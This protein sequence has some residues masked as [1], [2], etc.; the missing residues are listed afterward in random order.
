MSTKS[1]KITKNSPKS[2]FFV[3]QMIRFYKGMLEIPIIVCIL[4]WS[5]AK[6]NEKSK[7]FQKHGFLQCK[8][9]LFFRYFPVFSHIYIVKKT[10]FFVFFC[11]FLNYA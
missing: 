1:L 4:Q 10:R 11:F 3:F 7:R 6:K 5:A 2:D 8:T 9:S